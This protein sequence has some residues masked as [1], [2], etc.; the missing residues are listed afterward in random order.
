VIKPLLCS[1]AEAI[2]ALARDGY[3]CIVTGQYDSSPNSKR[4][5]TAT[6]EEVIAAGGACMTQCAH[7]IPDSTY[8]NVSKT[9][10]TEKAKVWP[11]LI[12]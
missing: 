2:Q 1:S 9:T 4:K 10:A 12:F 7:I 5:R 6:Q 8:F 11:F 3:R